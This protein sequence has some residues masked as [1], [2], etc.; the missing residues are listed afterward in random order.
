MVS[1][2]ELKAKLA[3]ATPPVPTFLV[4]AA[5]RAQPKRLKPSVLPPA[6]KSTACSE[7]GVTSRAMLRPT[8]RHPASTRPHR[9]PERATLTAVGV[10]SPQLRNPAGA[11][12]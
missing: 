3:M 5:G 10:K 9:P 2:V 4:I 11:L 7:R 12:A 8:D 6:P 1:A